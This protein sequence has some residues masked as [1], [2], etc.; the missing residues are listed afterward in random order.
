MIGWCNCQISGMGYPITANCAVD[1]PTKFE[2]II[3]V[4]IMEIINMYNLTKISTG[5]GEFA[6]F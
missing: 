3:L 6:I 5:N 1:E 2:K 4:M